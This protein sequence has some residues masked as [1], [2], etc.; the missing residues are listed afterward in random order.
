MTRTLAA[1]ALALAATASAPA[2]LAQGGTPKLCIFQPG[3]PMPTSTSGMQRLYLSE[4][5]DGQN[6]SNAT[7]NAKYKWSAKASQ[8]Y[9]QGY[10]NFSYAIFPVTTCRNTGNF[11]QPKTT[12]TVKA[13]PCNRP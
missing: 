11:F 7:Y 6:N 8:L 12:C 13:Q 1:F 9:G 10:S 2:A 4:Q 3:T 5:A